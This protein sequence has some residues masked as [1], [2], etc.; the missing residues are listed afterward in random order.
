[1]K[2]ERGVI[3]IGQILILVIGI[4]SFSGLV[5]AV[6]KAP[7]IWERI[8][9]FNEVAN[10]PARTSTGITDT[11]TF[12]QGNA[13]D[14]IISS[15]AWGIT[16]NVILRLPVLIIYN[17]WVDLNGNNYSSD[18]EFFGLGKK[19]FNLDKETMNVC[20][21]SNDYEGE[22]YF[23]T[24]TE[25]GELIGETK[26]H[27]ERNHAVGKMTRPN[28]DSSDGD[29]MDKLKEAGHGNYRITANTDDGK[30]YFVDVKIIRKEVK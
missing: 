26:M 30:T 12:A 17:K 27:A 4:I 11:W 29:F 19:V 15:A 5:S 10:A 23:R 16:A 25:A 21:K 7:P 20:I 24:W 8:Y 2:N 18:D 6:A 13:I 9:G 1:M 14:G 3:A 22:V 28:S